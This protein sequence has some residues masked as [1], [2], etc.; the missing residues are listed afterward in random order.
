MTGRTGWKQRARGHS[1][2]RMP[3]FRVLFSPRALRTCR[4]YFLQGKSDPVISQHTAADIMRDGYARLR[5]LAR[6]IVREEGGHTVQPTAAVHD[7]Y[8]RLRD[9]PTQDLR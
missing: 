3:A 6:R 7:A 4:P 9:V 8:L 2:D 5:R 1:N